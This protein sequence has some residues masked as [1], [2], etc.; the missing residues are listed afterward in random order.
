MLCMTDMAGLAD[1]AKADQDGTKGSGK[2]GCGGERESDFPMAFQD[3]VSQ[4]IQSLCTA[5][6]M[7]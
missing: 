7:H 1:N 4:A 6:N 3:K 5:G 2:S